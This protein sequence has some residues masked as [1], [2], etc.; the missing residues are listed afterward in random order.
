[1]I[2]CNVN[3]VAHSNKPSG[4]YELTLLSALQSISV[5]LSSTLLFWLTLTHRLHFQPQHAVVFSN[6]N[7]KKKKYG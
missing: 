5:S 3:R 4:D 1:M 7:N 6:N 2:K